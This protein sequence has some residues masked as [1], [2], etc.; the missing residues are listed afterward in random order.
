MQK[1]VRKFLTT[2]KRQVRQFDQSFKSEAVK[3]YNQDGR[4]LKK[5]ADNLGI[6]ISTLRDWVTKSKNYGEQAF[7]GKGHL[8]PQDEELFKLKKELIGV[9]EERDIL[10]KALAVFSRMQK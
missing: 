1:K 6:S 5:T 10:K 8:R 9:K 7:P 3:L 2:E 4:S